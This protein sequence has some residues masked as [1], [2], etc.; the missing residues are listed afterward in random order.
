MPLAFPLP[1]PRNA[2]LT[3]NDLC[4]LL[5]GEIGEEQGKKRGGGRGEKKIKTQSNLCV[6]SAL[7]SWHHGVVLHVYYNLPNNTAD[8]YCN[9]YF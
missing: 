9:F 7:S 3:H 6:L 1:P 8:N 5:E 4:D 2:A